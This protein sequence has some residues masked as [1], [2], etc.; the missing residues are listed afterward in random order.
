MC[1]RDSINAEYGGLSLDMS[2][3]AQERLR[4]ERKQWR[5]EHPYGFW[6]RLQ[7]GA[8]G[9]SDLMKWDCGVPGKAGTPWEDGVYKVSMEFSEDYPSKPP[10]CK[11]P[12]GFFHPNIYPSGTVCLNILND[13]KTGGWRP[14]ITIPQILSGIQTLLG[15]PNLEDPAQEPAYLLLRR[16]PA[17]YEARVRKEA[18]LYPRP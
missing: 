14:A 12:A 3:I 1:I 17:A 11:F 16:D 4:E 15:E 13:D 2:G 7:K 5:K 18:L 6:A 10:K 9:A 8:D